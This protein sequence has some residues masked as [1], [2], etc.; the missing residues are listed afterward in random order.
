MGHN[1]DVKI[2]IALQR[3]FALITVHVLN[4]YHHTL[5]PRSRQLPA[6]MT[7]PPTRLTKDDVIYD[8]TYDPSPFQHTPFSRHE[9]D[10]LHE[11]I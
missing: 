6:K 5:P 7:S 9:G 8:R 11:L 10:F 4:H 2:I 3:N 1:N